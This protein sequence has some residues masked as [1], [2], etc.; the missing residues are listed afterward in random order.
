M[1]IGY[2]IM[3]FGEEYGFVFYFLN[4]KQRKEPLFKKKQ[5]NK[6]RRVGKK[7]AV[8]GLTSR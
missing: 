3:C 6:P 4:V 7:N 2:L 1:Q 5:T 8:I